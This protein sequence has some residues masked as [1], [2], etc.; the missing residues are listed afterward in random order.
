MSHKTKPLLPN[1][2]QQPLPINDERERKKPR[3]AVSDARGKALCGLILEQ[4]KKQTK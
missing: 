2:G 1:P 4:L 3:G